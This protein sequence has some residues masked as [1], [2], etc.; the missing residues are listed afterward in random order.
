MKMERTEW[1]DGTPLVRHICDCGKAT[2]V[3]LAEVWTGTPFQ[4][5]HAS[6]GLRH[7]CPCEPK[8]ERPADADY[9]LGK[10]KKSA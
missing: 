2:I 4:E 10:R 3:C 9:W 5:W 8:R 7:Y 1:R 6:E